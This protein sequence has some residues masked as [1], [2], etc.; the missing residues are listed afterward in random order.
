AL[1][2]AGRRVERLHEL[3]PLPR[4]RQLVDQVLRRA[5][6]R[7]LRVARRGL[8][9][10]PA[11]GALAA[12]GEHAKRLAL[13]LR[14]LRAGERRDRLRLIAGARLEE[15]AE[16]AAHLGL[17]ERRVDGRDGRERGAVERREEA[18]AARR[19]GALVALLRL[20][21]ERRREELEALGRREALRDGGV[22]RARRG[23][24]PARAREELGRAAHVVLLERVERRAGE[25]ARHVL[26]VGLALGERARPGDDVGRASD[27]V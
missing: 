14:L 13:R 17:R 4:A 15:G 10:L 26:L 21:L 18:R 24:G 23:V 12:L 3:A 22:E 6:G 7:M 11:L 27:E 9:E 5:R 8:E 1:A 2:L 16:R 19:E 20:G 25:E